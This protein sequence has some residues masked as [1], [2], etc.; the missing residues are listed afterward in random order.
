[1]PDFT[2]HCAR[3]AAEESGEDLRLLYV[4]LT[5]AQ[6]QVFTWWAPSHNTASSPLH[7]LLLGHFAPGSEPPA[8]VRVPSD[9]EARRHFAELTRSSG[10][11]VVA[12]EVGDIAPSLWE[13]A[14]GQLLELSASSFRRHLDGAWRRTSYSAL[15]SAAH[16]GAPDI[17]VASEPGARALDDESAVVPVLVAGESDLAVPVLRSPM[18]DLPGGTG[19]GLVVHSVLESADANA[20]D[21]G[22]ELAQRSGEVLARR[23][24]ATYDAARL[25]AALLPSLETPLGPLAGNLRLRDITPADRIAELDFELP[26]AGGDDPVAAKVTLAGIAELLRRRLPADDAFAAYPDRLDGLEQQRLRG[27]LVGS[28]DAVLRVGSVSSPSFLVVDYKTNWLGASPAG[29]GALTT[30]DYRPSALREAMLAAHYPL[31]L[32]LY[33]VALH[34]FLRWRQPGYDADVHLG[35]GLYCFVRGM[36]GA[37]T[38]VSAGTPHGVFGWAPPP[39]LID[40]LS[41]L[42]AGEQP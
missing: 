35:G 11:C 22:A 39:G 9:A 38:P 16:D 28:I 26:L 12:E 36:A 8:K 14:A 33:L 4:A 1:V 34:R 21:L 42:L 24:G 3:N 19:F 25:A 15:T 37:Q 27:Y 40:A 7:R 32:L 2:D 6:C 20:A 18:A 29:S 30:T 5:R 13:P 10:G 23:L 31:Q 41:R 17:G